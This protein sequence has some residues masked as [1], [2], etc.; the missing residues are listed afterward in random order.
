MPRC[1]MLAVSGLAVHVA[2]GMHVS[3]G[4]ISACA[5]CMY[6][7]YHEHFKPQLDACK[8]W[9]HFMPRFMTVSSAQCELYMSP[10]NLYDSWHSFP[11]S[12]SGAEQ[13]VVTEHLRYSQRPLHANSAQTAH[14]V[15]KRTCGCLT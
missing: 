14:R 10:R 4:Y 5:V 8:T 11:D 13:Q 15:P 9:K 6:R 7:L 12:Q 1:C 3:Q 2:T